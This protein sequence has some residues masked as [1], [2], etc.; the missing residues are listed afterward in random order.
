[1][2]IITFLLACCIDYEYENLLLFNEL[3]LSTS[4]ALDSLLGTRAQI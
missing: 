4:H 1:M 3:L 2:M